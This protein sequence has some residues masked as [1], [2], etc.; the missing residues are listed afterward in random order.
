MVDKR[1]LCLT[2]LFLLLAF[3]NVPITHAQTIT[4]SITKVLVCSSVSGYGQYVQ[5]S[6]TI[7]LGETFYIYIEANILGTVSGVMGQRHLDAEFTINI[8]D[9]LGMTTFLGSSLPVSQ[10]VALG[11]PEPSWAWWQAVNSSQFVNYINGNYRFQVGLLDFAANVNTSVSRTFTLRGAFPGQVVFNVNDNV[12]FTN[13]Q[14]SESYS[15]PLL[16]MVEIPNIGSYQ[17]VLDGPRANIQ[18]QGIGE[19]DYGNRYMLFKDMALAP[20]ANLTIDVTYTVRIKLTNLIGNATAQFSTLQNLPN[21]T[22]EY[23]RPTQYIESDSPVFKGIANRFREKSANVLQLID[24]LDNFTANY[25]TYDTVALSDSNRLSLDNQD[26]ALATYAKGTGVCTNYSRLLVALLR[27]A[28]IPA[29][30]VDGWAVDSSLPGISYTDTI[31]HVWVELYLPGTGWVPVEPQNPSTL[32][33]TLGSYILFDF[34]GSERNVNV[35]GYNGTIFPIY[36]WSSST[37][38]L[39]SSEVFSHVATLSYNGNPSSKYETVSAP[40]IPNSTEITSNEL[41][42]ATTLPTITLTVTIGF[43]ILAAPFIAIVG[44]IV[45]VIRRRKRRS[46]SQPP[47]GIS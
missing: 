5:R 9:P 33:F 37:A 12:V 14:S 17:T 6:S 16:R 24:Y 19:D 42:N 41:I 40:I 44:A 4:S 34:S 7:N 47:A 26:S 32:G 43:L 20:G 25:V 11:N 10:Y 29:R 15:L 28:G 46:A 39:T 1:K 18:P 31:R 45:F 21:A 23:L 8:T 35:D 13:N 38:N 2:F 30:I 36:Y 27:A 22:E 3:G